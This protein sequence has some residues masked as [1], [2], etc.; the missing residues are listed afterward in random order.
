MEVDQ[1]HEEVP[2]DQEEDATRKPLAPISLPILQTVR[3]AQAQHGLRHNDFARYRSYCTRKLGRLY[4]AHGLTHGRGKYVRRTLE[5]NH[6]NSHGHLLIPLVAAER[7]WALAMKL[8]SDLEK[9]KAPRKR[10]HLVRRLAKAQ[11]HAGTLASLA[12]ARG[13][14]RTALEAQAYAALM[15]GTW[16]LEKETDWGTALKK[17]Q[18][19]QQICEQLARVGTPDQVAVTQ[20]QLQ[21]L[22][23]QIRY[24]QYQL[25][26]RGGLSTEGV[27]DSPSAAGLQARLNALAEEAG[28]SAEAAAD[29]GTAKAG[30]TLF[31]WRGS[32]HPVQAERIR[33]SLAAAAEA[34]HALSQI[35]KGSDERTGALDSQIAAYNEAKG[36]IR[37]ALSTTAGGAAASDAQADLRALNAAVTGAQ[38]E[39]TLERGCLAVARAESAL[40]QSLRACSSFEAQGVKP[41]EVVR[42]YDGLGQACKEMKDVAAQIGGANGELLMDEAS[43]KALQFQASRCYYAAHAYLAGGNPQAAYA[44]FQRVGSR[45]DTAISQH[46]DCARVDKEAC[47]KLEGLKAAAQVWQCVAQADCAAEQQ[48]HIEEAGGKVEQLSLEQTSSKEYLLDNLDKWQ[49]FA[50]EAG[51][52]ARLFPVPPRPLYIPMRP[53]LLDAAQAFISPPS[54]DHRLRAEQKTG[55][56]ASLFGWRK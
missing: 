41:Q 23:P 37:H 39:G 2:A 45:A 25:Q 27:P 51:R 53:F 30:V 43:A 12:S 19:T 24:C 42:M 33:T 4:R 14:A 55:G 32:S 1:P 21:E 26:R 15:T 22:E 6:I 47:D 34:T 8:K 17:F 35:P 31:T 13:D 48:Q 7:A 29:Q 20:Q 38:L 5:A 54:L 10:L 46:E 50:G 3:A 56:I 9:S 40:E 36:Y 49:A 18:R 52:E 44:L 28:S 11:V 16:L